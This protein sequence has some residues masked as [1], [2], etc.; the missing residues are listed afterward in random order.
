GEQAD[1]LGDDLAGSERAGAVAHPIGM[2]LGARLERLLARP[3]HLHRPPGPERQEPEVH[4][5]GDVLFATEAAAEIRADYADAV[6][7]DLERLGDV[8]E[9]LDHLRSYADRDH[10]VG[11]SPL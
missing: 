5:D 7:R 10:V 11:G 1:L 9:M 2:A 3:D 8:A 4:L 6:L